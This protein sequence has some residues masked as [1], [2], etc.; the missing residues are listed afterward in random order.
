MIRSLTVSERA[1]IGDYIRL[2]S[3]VEVARHRGRSVK[4]IERQTQAARDKCGGL[5]LV[6]L[7]IVVD[8][9]SFV[10]FGLPVLSKGEHAAINDRQVRILEEALS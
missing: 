8:R 6:Q 1:V 2:G 10:S 3:L 4:T 7:A 5:T 9:Y